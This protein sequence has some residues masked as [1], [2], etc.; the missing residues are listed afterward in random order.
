[1][2]LGNKINVLIL[3]ASR[4]Y[5]AQLA[6]ILNTR[7][8]ANVTHVIDENRLF[9]SFV[10]YNPDIVIYDLFS[11]FNQFGIN[12]EVIQRKFPKSKVIVLSFETDPNLVDMCIEK[13]AKG[14]FDKSVKDIE[15][16]ASSIKKVINDET[17]ILN[18]HSSNAIAS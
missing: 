15:L 12:M 9:S 18:S 16:L 3:D 8:R 5:S 7:L 1:M 17:T 10:K 13:G 4:F 11:T 2:K 14:F 6:G